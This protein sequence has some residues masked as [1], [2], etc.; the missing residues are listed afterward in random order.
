MRITG[1]GV[2]GPPADRTSHRVLRRARGA[3][4]RLH[5]HR[6]LLRALRRRGADHGG[7]A[8]LRRGCG[9][10]D[11]GR[12]AAHGP[13][14]VAYRSAP[15]YLRQ[16][17]ELSLR[18]LGLERID[19]YQLH[20]I[21]PTGPAGGSWASS[22][23]CRRRARSAT[24]AC[25]RW[26]VEEIEGA[27][28]VAESFGAE[29][30]QPRPTASTRRSSTTCEKENLASSRGS[31]SPTGGLARPGGTLR[32]VAAE[33]GATPAQLALSWLLPALPGD[34]ADPR[35]VHRE[36]P[37]GEPRRRRRHPHRRRV[38]DVEQGR[39]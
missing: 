20:R 12:A 10:R 23:R 18:R 9:D 38:R 17:L 26:A 22:Q 4:R 21:D 8:P 37:G 7:A 16:E 34:A 5:R 2:W 6:G 39:R 25:Q 27:R 15:G 24:S 13:G 32:S 3:R 29:P 28:D 19:L 14:R 35:H 31:R 33:H 11:Q 30:L 36:A 1:N